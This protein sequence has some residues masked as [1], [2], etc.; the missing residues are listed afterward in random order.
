MQFSDLRRAEGAKA[1]FVGTLT[2]T[3]GDSNYELSISG[4]PALIKQVFAES[5]FEAQIEPRATETDWIPRYQDIWAGK[6]GVDA[7]LAG[8][9]TIAA[10]DKAPSAE[11]P[12]TA[13]NSIVVSV[14]R[15]KG[16]G[17]WWWLW[18]PG[19]AIPRGASMFFVLPP[20]CNCAGFVQP[21]AGD[22]DLF[23]RQNGP[24]APVVASSTRGPGQIDR[25]SFGPPICW[26]WQEFVPW[27]QVRAFST[28]VA[29]FG[30]SG[31]G[32]VP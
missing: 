28:C 21:V 4:Q 31:F 23:L 2:D 6:T 18:F 8:P 16:Q 5:E 32:V 15:T 11:T 27:F 9:E 24:F 26:P 25:V 7:D 20:I 3:A 12:P 10:L 30:M 1:V 22:P 17:T 29:N 13:K 14:R 19:L